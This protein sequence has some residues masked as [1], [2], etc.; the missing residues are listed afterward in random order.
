MKGDFD[1]IRRILHEIEKLPAGESL[2]GLEYSDDNDQETVYAHTKLLIEK[3][4]IEGEIIGGTGGSMTR[5]TDL[6]WAGHDFLDTSKDDTIWAKGKVSVLKPTASFTF[7]LLL[8]WLKTEAKKK[9]G[10]P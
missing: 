3:G 9:L 2:E 6:T 7:D 4:L 10:L 5:V 1:L 8:Q